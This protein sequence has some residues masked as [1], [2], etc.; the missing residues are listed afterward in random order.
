[1]QES[2]ND[3]DIEQLQGNPAGMSISD[4][5]VHLQPSLVQNFVLLQNQIS[6]WKISTK[7]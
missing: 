5:W 4:P 6:F 1:M 3:V 2:E 7:F